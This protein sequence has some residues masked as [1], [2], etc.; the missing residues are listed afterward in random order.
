M[1]KAEARLEDRKLGPISE[2]GSHHLLC[3]SAIE[4][5]EAGCASHSLETTNPSH[6]GS[7]LSPFVPLSLKRIF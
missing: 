5:P 1:E 3:Q 6:F 7:C 2:E 4:A